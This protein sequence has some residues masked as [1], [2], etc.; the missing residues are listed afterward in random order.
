VY[1]ALARHFQLTRAD[2]DE[3]IYE[4]NGAPRSKWENMVRWVRND[5]KKKGMLVMPSHGV[6][7]LSREARSVIEAKRSG[8]QNRT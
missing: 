4:Q 7:A 5:L 1:E 6:W 2:L 8:K 3:K